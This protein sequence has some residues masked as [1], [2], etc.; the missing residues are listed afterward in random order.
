MYILSI[1]TARLRSGGTQ[2]SNASLNK[3]DP[4]FGNDSVELINFNPGDVDGTRILVPDVEVYK[5][6]MNSLIHFSDENFAAKVNVNTLNREGLAPIHRAVRINDVG[7]VAS[8]LQS[9]ADINLAD[10]TG[11]TPLITAARYTQVVRQPHILITLH[12]DILNLDRAEYSF[13]FF[14]FD[15]NLSLFYNNNRIGEK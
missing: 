6:S 14:S 2:R 15:L 5:P 13:S 8:L 11:L 3:V 9:G 4:W 1:D 10:R 12:R 7:A